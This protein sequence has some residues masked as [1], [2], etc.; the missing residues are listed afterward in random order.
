MNKKLIIALNC[1]WGII[2][3]FIGLI[4]SLVC[5]ATGKFNIKKCKNSPL[6]AIV[7]KSDYSMGSATLGLFCITG[8]YNYEHGIVDAPIEFS[9]MDHE[10]GHTIQN[11]LTGPAMIIVALCSLIWCGIIHP[12]KKKKDPSLSYYSFWTESWANELGL[13]YK[14]NTLK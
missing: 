6:I 14:V 13:Q 12:L 2:L 7:L 4:A 11:A 3:T 8:K 9:V 1:T 5:L 10:W